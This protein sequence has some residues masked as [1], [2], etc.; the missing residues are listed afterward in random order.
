MESLIIEPSAKNIKDHLKEV[1]ALILIIF[2]TLCILFNLYY[3]F[4][5][6]RTAQEV[7]YLGYIGD[8][9][10]RALKVLIIP[11]IGASTI[12][13]Y[14]KGEFSEI[15]TFVVKF[16]SAIIIATTFVFIICILF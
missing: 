10:L 4:G 11:L 1:I 7:L 8:L 13:I 9:Y 6:S 12:T 2:V 15:A 3:S 14:A 16:I 5:E